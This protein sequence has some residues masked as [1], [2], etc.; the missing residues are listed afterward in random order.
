MSAEKI[1]SWLAISWATDLLFHCLFSISFCLQDSH[2]KFPTLSWPFSLNKAMVCDQNFQTPEHILCGW[3]CGCVFNVLYICITQ[4]LLLLLL[5]S[6]TP[7]MFRSL[8]RLLTSLIG[9][10][11]ASVTTLLYYS[12]LLPQNII[13]Q[14]LVRRQFLHEENYLFHFLINFLRCFW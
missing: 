5:Q 13:F 11:A 8:V 10:P 6:I 14:R 4:V 1:G 12:D 3:T 7:L 2:T 9:E